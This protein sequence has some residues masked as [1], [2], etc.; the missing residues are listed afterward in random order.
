M[1]RI[2]TT[3]GRPAS[4][5]SCLSGIIALLCCITVSSL[6]ALAADAPAFDPLFSTPGIQY[7]ADQVPP[8]P[9]TQQP[10]DAQ[11]S[12]QQVPREIYVNA[13]SDGSI[14]PEFSNPPAGVIV[15]VVPF[16]Q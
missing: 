14:P 16:G 8:L 10:A 4:A 5:F 9:P 3:Q 15:H 13:L 12:P 1:P 2:N 11:S 7:R 6:S